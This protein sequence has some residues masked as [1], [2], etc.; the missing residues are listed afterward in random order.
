MST[1]N[2]YAFKAE[3]NKVLKIITHSLYQKPEVFLR[4]LISNSSDAL[5]KVRLKKLTSD[6]ILDADAELAIR[7]SPDKDNKTLTISDTGIGMTKQEL[8]ENLGTI[9]QS[10]T[11]QFLQAIEDGT[12]DTSELI[13]MFGVGFYS[14]FLVA[15]K[16]EVIT[17][18][19]SPQSNAWKWV[20]DGEDS[21]T[22]EPAEKSTRGTDIILH[23]KEDEEEYLEGYR[24]RSLVKR[25]SNYVAFPVKLVKEEPEEDEEPEETINDQTALW[26]QNPDEISEEDYEEF[27]HHLGQGGKPLA[28]VHVRV[29]S[30]IQFF[31]VLFIPSMKPMNFNNNDKWGLTLYNR[32]VLINENNQDLLPEWARFVVGVVDGEDLKLNVSREVLQSTRTTRTIEKYITKKLIQKI[33]EMSEE[34]DDDE[35]MEFWREFGPFIKEGIAQEAKYKD[36]LTELLRFHS[37]AKEGKDGSVSLEDY[38]TRMKPDQDKIYY[39]T[40]LELDLLKKSPHL[41]YYKQNNLEVLLLGEAI[42]SFLMMHLQDYHEKQFFLIDQDEEEEDTKDE[43]TTASDDDEEGEDEDKKK[44][45]PF[46]PLLNRTL[47]VLDG[48]IKD[49]KTSDRLVGSVARLVTPSGGI[50]SNLQ[51]AMR[52]MEAQGGGAGMNLPMMGKVLQLNPNHELV[53]QLNNLIQTNADDQRIDMMIKQIHDNAR[54]LE[55]DVPDFTD[56]LS[57]LEDIMSFA[58]KDE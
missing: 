47:E 49:V 34:E 39:L 24:L 5:N 35:Y 2:T 10:G 21:F 33:E 22:I 40:G 6:N 54:I 16:V 1:E 7:I 44:T 31:A 55:G 36:R 27:Y 53:K 58:V 17:R 38:V 20:S 45:G 13:G 52:I 15:D 50:N 41:E 12:T 29:E 4:E 8:T 42:D 37:T 14:A 18:S 28:T 57:R 11:E 51:R 43:E 32:K 9:A 25:Y 30:P 23:L 56:M 48:K 3:T 26:R 19:S 46:A